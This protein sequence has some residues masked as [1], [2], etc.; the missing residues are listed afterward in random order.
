MKAVLLSEFGGIENLK[1]ADIPAPDPKEDEVVLRVEAFGINPVD[2]KAR[3]GKAFAAKLKNVNFPVILGKDVAGTV[4]K[5]GEN[6]NHFE[7]GDRVYGVANNDSGFGNTY[8]EYTH[9]TT[10]SLFKIPKNI[11]SE[12]AA[13]SPIAA[14]TALQALREKVELK[15]EHTILIHAGAGGVGHFAIQYAKY[16]GAHVTAS[17]SMANKE[18]IL[19][20]LGADAHIDYKTV[21]YDA[22]ENAFDVVLDLVGLDNIDN[23]IKTTKPGG[24]VICVPSNSFD[25]FREKVTKKNVN[26]HT[27]LMHPDNEWLCYLANMLKK[28]ILVPHISQKA[29][30]FEIKEV[31]KQIESGSTK[32]KIVVVP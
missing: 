4:V 26:G 29:A 8:A 10:E 23:A 16:V 5:K 31:H 22:Y 32:G 17:S 19:N 12:V 11:S 1:I 28:G 20:T 18:F 24:D 25:V 15:K 30:L 7:I 6:V 27:L 13:S 14:L 3:Q 9:S 2:A 21:N